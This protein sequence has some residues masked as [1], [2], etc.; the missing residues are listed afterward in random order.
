MWDDVEIVSIDQARAHARLL[1][2]GSPPSAEEEDHI[3][4]LRQAHGLVLDYINRPSDEDWTEEIL[5][6][7]AET[8]P[9]AV[10]AAIMRQFAELVRFRGDDDDDR[11]AGDGTDLSP[12]VKQLLRMYRTPVVA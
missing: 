11:G 1:P 3:L 7:D 5:A 9:A 6:W 10:Q 12:R 8:A 2:A 4:K